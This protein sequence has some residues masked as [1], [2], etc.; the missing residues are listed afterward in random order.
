M[1]IFQLDLAEF[2]FLFLFFFFL[3]NPNNVNVFTALIESLWVK[4]SPDLPCWKTY[5]SPQLWVTERVRVRE[6]GKEIERERAGGAP[7]T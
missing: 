7:V 5:S 1:C 2:I 6:R 4:C 3:N